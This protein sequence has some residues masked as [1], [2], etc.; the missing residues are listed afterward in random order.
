M[1]GLMFLFW[2]APKKGFF[3]ERIR[4]DWP[5]LLFGLWVVWNGISMS[6]TQRLE[7]GFNQWIIQLPLLLFPVGILSMNR[8]RKPE[9]RL[10]ENG[11]MLSLLLAWLIT[12]A[13][14]LGVF[15]TTD[16]PWDEAFTY[17]TF[18]ERILQHPTYLAL[19]VNI[20]LIFL[21]YRSPMKHGDIWLIT[22]FILFLLMTAARLQVFLGIGII[23]AVVFFRYPTYRKWVGVGILGITLLGI[24]AIAL[25]PEEA[26]RLR[27]LWE[28]ENVENVRYSGTAVRIALWNGCL[29]EIS[30]NPWWGIGIGGVQ[31]ALE[32]TYQAKGLNLTGL[33]PHNQYLST[34]MSLGVPGLLLLVASLFIPLWKAIRQKRFVAATLL[35]LFIMGCLTEDLLSRQ[36]G[37]CILAIWLPI[38]WEM[39]DTNP[40]EEKESMPALRQVDTK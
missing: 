35:I 27:D 32:A 6:Y 25:F 38:T 26:E 1:T 22:G 34:T 39:R 29:E 30:Q 20:A 10:F 36:I 9:I 13:I 37:V 17:A 33:G 23:A 18:T 31:P 4:N 8:F 21:L 19:M 5:I 40:G 7:T 12:L 15:I 14:G 24:L 16:I 3:T 11:F 28:Y 2:F